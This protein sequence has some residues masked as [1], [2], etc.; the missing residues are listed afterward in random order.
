MKPV[1]FVANCLSEKLEPCPFCGGK[2]Q[3]VFFIICTD[4]DDPDTA[5]P[6]IEIHCT[7]CPAIMPLSNDLVEKWNS[8][9]KVDGRLKRK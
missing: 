1:R 9:K 7:K 3:M 6:Q 4:E 5:V 8:R 2:A